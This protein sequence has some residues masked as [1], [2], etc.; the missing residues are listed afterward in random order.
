MKDIESLKRVLLPGFQEARAKLNN[1]FWD[2]FSEEGRLAIRK[3]I[4]TTVGSIIASLRM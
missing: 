3:Y 1:D 2:R 4:R